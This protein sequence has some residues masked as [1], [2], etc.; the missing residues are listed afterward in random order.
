MPEGGVAGRAEQF[1]TPRRLGHEMLL[2]EEP[3][4]L[5]DGLA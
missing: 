1:A 4:R 3:G 2:S 5:L